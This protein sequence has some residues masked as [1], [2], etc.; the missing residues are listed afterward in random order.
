MSI[1]SSN[2][3]FHFTER[4][5]LLSILEH[6]F[7]PRYCL[8][9]YE[10]NKNKFKL[11]VPMV[12]FCDIALSQIKKHVKVYGSYGIGMTK[13]W[14]DKH[15]LNPVLYL[16]NNSTLSDNVMNM[17]LS[18]SSNDMN[19]LTEHDDSKRNLL[20]VLRYLKPYESILLRPF[21]EIRKRFYDERE[22]RY[23]P[24]PQDYKSKN[25]V[26]SEDEY[27]N[28]DLRSDANLKL[29]NAKLGFHPNDIRYIIVDNQDEIPEMIEHLRNKAE[30]FEFDEHTLQLL[31]SRILTYEQ[32]DEDF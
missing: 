5:Y 12:C 7:Y 16:K 9:K 21:E 25:Y 6:G 2:T 1:I 20:E 13:T 30:K 28:E 26:L 15:K 18:I 3:L 14:G 17:I 10:S 32:I 27:N 8:E 22:W 29:Q 24:N 23:V 11:A 4:G 31:T 19:S